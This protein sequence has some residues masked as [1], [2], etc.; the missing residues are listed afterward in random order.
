M[1]AYKEHPYQRPGKAKGSPARYEFFKEIVKVF[2]D[3]GRGVLV[4][5]DKHLSW[6]WDWAKEMYD[7]SL[8]MKF[9]LMAGSSLP[10]RVR[11]PTT[12]SIS[13]AGEPRPPRRVHR[14]APTDLPGCIK[15]L[16]LLA[17]IQIM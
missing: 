15:I 9:P 12:C 17:A 13:I 3:S 7:T 8:R 16:P 1:L 2:N 10:P 11:A 14:C 6:N 5:N 4:F